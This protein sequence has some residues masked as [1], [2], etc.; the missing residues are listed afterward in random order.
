[1][2]RIGWLR[3]LNSELNIEELRNQFNEIYKEGGIY[4]AEFRI[5]EKDNIVI[6]IPLNINIEGYDFVEYSRLML[7]N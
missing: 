6:N 7:M 5:Y 3:I 1:M 4:R 2:D